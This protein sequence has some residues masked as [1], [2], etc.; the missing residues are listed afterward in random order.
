MTKKMEQR[1]E[2]YRRWLHRTGVAR[3][4]LAA[5]PAMI[6]RD[7]SNYRMVVD[8]DLCPRTDGETI[9]VSLI[10]PCLEEDL[11][12]VD[13][14]ICLRAAAGHEC[15]HINWSSF[16]D[17]AE[18]SEWY[19]EYLHT[20]FSLDKQIG[21]SIAAHG[22][23]IVEDG[24][25]ERISATLRPGLELPYRFMN[26]LIRAGTEIASKA[27][28]PEGE[29]D[30]FWGNLLSYAKT[31]CYAPGV[32]A[33]QRTPMED[34]FLSVRS[35]IDEAISSNQSQQCKV[36]IQTMLEDLS[37]YLVSLI[38]GS[39]ALMDRLMGPQDLPEYGSDG[40]DPSMTPQQAA[41]PGIRKTPAPSPSGQ[42]G[43][44][45]PGEKAGGKNSQDASSGGKSDQTQG[46]AS[47]SSGQS[48]SNSSVGF[49]TSDDEEPP[50]DKAALDQLRNSLQTQ[51]DAATQSNAQQEAG[52][53]R[54]DEVASDIGKIKAVYGSGT[55]DM[56]VGK[57]SFA[58]SA[59]SGPM[60]ETIRLQASVLRQ[61]LNRIL[62][63][64]RKSLR[65][66]NRGQIDPGALWRYGLKEPIFHQE[67]NRSAGSTAVYLL[68][69]NSGSMASDISEQSDVSK[70]TAAR[71][72]A[73]VVE[74]ATKGLIPCKAALFSTKSSGVQHLV[75]RDFDE[76]TSKNSC[77][78]SL[79][80]CGPGGTN[81]DSANI[82]LAT[83]ELE[84]RREKKRVLLVLSDGEPSA[85]SSQASA[86]VEVREAVREARRKGVIVIPIMFGSSHF[87]EASREA[88]SRMYEKDILACEP[89]EITARLANLIRE[90]VK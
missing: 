34:A 56:E 77:W 35:L 58:A 36:L 57:L 42:D 10:P 81:C 24:R 23:N 8:D 5:L 54:Q 3:M 52:S 30:D 47:K 90:L 63:D 4:L 85:F 55:R 59:G 62:A 39:Q 78:E 33:Y 38:R 21:R 13:W 46:D 9:Y 84:R 28:N 29:F 19:G 82:R 75:L 65:G 41:G 80:V 22:M 53:S 26:R 18:L 16:S 89:R 49:G 67:G 50:L 79:G 87:L 68:I 76:A 25:I 20:N 2:D 51:M 1:L 86:E 32:A 72:A 45:V 71:L 74:E 43:S 66:M 48:D 44:G 15:G 73:A 64:R 37:P 27:E 40:A 14:M 88:Y 31:G 11:S 70:S 7:S 60:P 61:T 17:M 69:D 12:E 83:A 6:E